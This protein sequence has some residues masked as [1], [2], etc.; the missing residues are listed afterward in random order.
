[1]LGNFTLEWRVIKRETFEIA[2][3]NLGA[4]DLRPRGFMIVH[5]ETMLVAN[6]VKGEEKIPTIKEKGKCASDESGFFVY[7]EDYF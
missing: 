3:F 4:N 5:K 7:N 2:E 1:M 6:V